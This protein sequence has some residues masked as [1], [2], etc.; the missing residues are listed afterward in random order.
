VEFRGSARPAPDQIAAIG[1]RLERADPPLPGSPAAWRGVVDADGRVRTMGVPPG[2]Y[3]VRVTGAPRGW[4]PA[5]AIVGGVDALD[6]PVTIATGDL[7]GLLVTFGD[8]HAAVLST[9][10]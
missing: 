9:A 10:R 8:R 2:R 6:V 1:V 5:S 3:L 7:E 4:T